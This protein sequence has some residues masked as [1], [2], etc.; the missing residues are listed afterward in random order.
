MFASKVISESPY[1]PLCNICGKIT[2]E[3]AMNTSVSESTVVC[4]SSLVIQQ[5]FENC[6]LR[7]LQSYP[8]ILLK[9][10][11]YHACHLFFIIV[12]DICSSVI[13]VSC[14]T[15]DIPSNGSVDTSTGTSF[16]DVARYSCDTGYTLS[17]TAEITCQVDG[18]WS[19]RVPACK[20]EIMQ[21]I[22]INCAVLPVSISIFNL[23]CVLV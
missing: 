2:N 7:L 23:F 4:L 19:G 3:F 17:G 10:F 8:L 21:C 13:G 15:P 11:R 9:R 6:I 1:L 16:G 18:Q 20:G 12:T 14:G 5:M 22:E